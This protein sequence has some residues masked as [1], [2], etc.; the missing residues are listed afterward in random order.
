[1][2]AQVVLAARDVHKRFRVGRRGLSGAAGVVH[3]LSGV[4]LVLPAGETLGIV[5]ESGSGKSTLAQLLVGM[6]RPS[7]GE[8]TLLGEPLH[9]LRGRD[10]RRARRNIQLVHQDPYTSL[11]PRM[12]VSSIV[13]EPLDIHRGVVP[14]REIRR[15]VG[16]LLELVGLNPDHADRYPHQFSGGQRQRIG[17]ARALALRPRVLVCDEPV[18][19]LDV[20]VQAQIINLF[21]R[22]RGELG[23]SYVFISHDL[24]VVQHI[25]DRVAVMYLGKVV[26]QGT[27][28]EV[29]ESPQHPYTKALLAAIPAPDR[30]LRNVRRRLVLV[31]D[32]PSPLTPPSGCHFHPRCWIAQE[33]CSVEAP[34]LESKGESSGHLAAC[35][36]PLP[37]G[38][39]PGVEVERALS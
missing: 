31:G 34:L 15:T 1:M 39:E 33:R 5:G 9:L 10:L 12:T 36:F 28:D 18:S 13:R 11:D 26:E 6:Q 27:Y 37:I 19:A 14:R 24:G 32:P 21:E 30:S 25:A 7:S 4:D 20:S 22:L 3:A 8:V 35:H 17:I 29:Y 38:Y 16:E 23:L 2:S